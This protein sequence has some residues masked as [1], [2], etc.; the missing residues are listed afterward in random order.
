MG[1]ANWSRGGKAGGSTGT[2]L[3]VRLAL[4]GLG[5]LGAIA[6]GATTIR[7]HDDNAANLAKDV[8]P[9][10]ALAAGAPATMPAPGP[11]RVGIN[12]FAVEAWGRQQ[13]F[14]NMVAQ[15]EWFNSQGQGWTSFPTDQ[16]D[17][18]GWVRYLKPGQTAFLRLALPAAPFQPAAVM[19]SFQGQGVV[20]AGGV[21]EL[22]NRGPQSF[23]LDLKP[24]GAEGDIAWIELAKTDPQDPVRNIDCRLADRPV[25]ERYTPEFLSF[26]RQFKIIRFLDW[27][28][29]NDN[30]PVNW[31]TRPTPRSASQASPGGV[32]IED[33]VDLADATS[34]DPWFLVPY[35]ADP[36]Y[37]RAFARLVHD[38]LDPKRT[39]YVELSNEV[40]N[41]VF[42][43]S[44]QAQAEGVALGLAKGDPMRATML[45]YAQKL[46]G[47]MRIWTEVFADRPHQLVRVASS[48]NAW[49]DLAGII[50][51]DADT[52]HWIDALATAP[53]FGFDLDK[54]GPEDLDRIFAKAPSVMEQALNNAMIHRELAA[55]Y[56]KRYITY[57]AGQ[58]F[59]TKDM[60]L[61][62][63]LQR[64]PRMG[65]LYTDYLDQ[66][67]KRF[68]GDMVLFSSTAPIGTYGGWGLREYAG[69]P[70]E[71]A[72]KYHAV[73]RFL[74]ELNRS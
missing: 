42:D 52:A 1:W 30:A 5:L 56:G 65:A 60:D 36:A 7:S 62:Y 19:C 68:G 63:A 70:E 69:Q 41:S 59:V 3:H 74:A 67:K 61:A 17:A 12:L 49:P 39:V 58:H 9:S 57:E 27:Q 16:L 18:L 35:K 2:A 43:V 20:D 44:S 50:L 72:P 66:W 51:G 40:W 46:R 6:V 33:M 21:A 28:K 4:A 53:Y 55:R 25:D 22:R 54:Y 10:P 15:S 13:V 31:D 48:Q 45:R 64:D 71:Q 38:R 26:V 24:T 73:R 47:T 14:A 8:T 34:T 11:M 23:M 32:S 29:I 37:T